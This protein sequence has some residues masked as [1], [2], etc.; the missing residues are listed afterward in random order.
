MSWT[1]QDLKEFASTPVAQA[2][3][4]LIIRWTKYLLSPS[5]RQVAP[6]GW[7]DEQHDYDGDLPSVVTVRNALDAEKCEYLPVASEHQTLSGSRLH[8]LWHIVTGKP[9]ND[10]H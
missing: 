8:N 2:S 7:H 10:P 9:F 6:G 5:P 1:E 3:D 4:E